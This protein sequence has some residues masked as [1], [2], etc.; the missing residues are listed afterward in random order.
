MQSFLLG[1]KGTHPLPL[2][3]AAGALIGA[4]S[5]A[6]GGGGNDD[7]GMGGSGGTGVDGSGGSAN[8]GR[9]VIEDATEDCDEVD[10]LNGEAILEATGLTFSGDLSWTDLETGYEAS[11]TIVEV[12]VTIQAGG[13]FTC[14]PFR[15]YPGQPAEYARLSYDGATLSMTTEDGLLAE[16]G[17]AVVWLA[18]TSNPGAL[19]LDVVRALPA[20][21]AEGSF[22]VSPSLSDDYQTLSMVYTPSPDMPLGYVS[23]AREPA[24]EMLD[25]GKVTAGVPHGY[26]PAL[27]PP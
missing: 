27:A 9:Y 25:N 2:V 17:P 22:E 3:L 23:V 16:S 20:A 1:R 14:I 12:E 7:A 4:L 11:R 24:S 18:E 13:T 8:D 6:C 21:D 26:F 15:Q 5:S 19:D 10:G